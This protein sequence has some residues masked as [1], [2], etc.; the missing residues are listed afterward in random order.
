MMWVKTWIISNVPGS[1]SCAGLI[2]VFLYFDNG[3]TS[4]WA[5]CMQLKKRKQSKCRDAKS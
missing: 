3:M 5:E 2:S 4:P 1:L